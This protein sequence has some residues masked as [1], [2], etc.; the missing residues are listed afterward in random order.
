MNRLEV[1]VT[2][3]GYDALEA[4]LESDRS[5]PECLLLSDLD[6]FLTGIAI[7]PDRVMPS[8]WLPVVWGGEKPVFASESEAQEVLGGIMSR[9]NEILRQ[10]EDGTFAPIFWV[11][12]DDTVIAADWAEGFA[13]AMSLR[14]EAWDPIFK[15]KRHALALFPILA[16]C[17]DEN[18]ESALGLDRDAEQEIMEEAPKVLPGAVLAIA[19]FWRKRR[20]GRSGNPVKNR[21]ITAARTVPKAGRK[22]P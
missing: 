3:V 6:G 20:A 9:Y 4:F 8:E 15:S 17:G 11:K 2:D 10:V 19:A 14:P 21:T 16:L 13:I 7:G 22:D 12:A 18:G 5:P 1:P